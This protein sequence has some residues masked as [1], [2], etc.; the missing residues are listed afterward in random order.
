MINKILK[1]ISNKKNDIFLN[2]LKISFSKKITHNIRKIYKVNVLNSFWKNSWELFQCKA[3]LDFPEPGNETRLQKKKKKNDRRVIPRAVSTRIAQRKK[4]NK[5][6]N[7]KKKRVRDQVSGWS[8]AEIVEFGESFFR[9]AS[10][11][12][13]R[14]VTSPTNSWPNSLSRVE[15]TLHSAFLK[16]FVRQ[17]YFHL[18]SSALTLFCNFF[19][20]I[21]IFFSRGNTAVLWSQVECM[22]L[23]ETLNH[24]LFFSWIVTLYFLLQRSPHSSYDSIF[25]LNLFSL[26]YSAYFFFARCIF[27]KFFHVN[28]NKF[29]NFPFHHTENSSTHF[30]HYLRYKDIPIGVYVKYQWHLFKNINRIFTLVKLHLKKMIK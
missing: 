25:F 9:E 21:Y 27:S 1:N 19:F 22:P 4:K 26:S 6:E 7:V 5:S 28:I 15:T 20:Y 8:L 23:S 2:V 12:R 30:N 13:K 3:Q 10:S 29:F 14:R 18:F 17:F 11:T 24:S 16:S